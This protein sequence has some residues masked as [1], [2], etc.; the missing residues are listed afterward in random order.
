MAKSFREAQKANDCIQRRW[1]QAYKEGNVVEMYVATVDFDKNIKQQEEALKTM[2]PNSK[3]YDRAQQS[4]DAQK[5][6]RWDMKYEQCR[7]N[8]GSEKQQDIDK[9][10][11]KNYDLDKQMDKA[12][13]KGDMRRYDQLKSQY[14]NNVAAQEQLCK[15]AKAEGYE[16][17]Q[18]IIAQKTVGVDKDIQMRDKLSSKENNG[19]KLS[20]EEKQNLQ[21]Y[22]DNIRKGE[23]D[24][25]RYQNETKYSGMKD[26]NVPQQEIDAQRK[27]DNAKVEQFE[28][29]GRI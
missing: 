12:I 20:A 2:N 11:A 23:S 7:V 5:Q 6:Q 9:L 24:Q 28:R 17:K 3:E 29:T 21:K 16:P 15:D 8:F 26:R 4:L 14:D 19:Q 22:C 27:E 1:E 18:D 13:E 10:S 25:L